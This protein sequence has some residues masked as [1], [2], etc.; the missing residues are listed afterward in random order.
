MSDAPYGVR[1]WRSSR[2]DDELYADGLTV[3]EDLLEHVA[4][5]LAVNADRRRAAA[6]AHSLWEHMRLCGEQDA[7]EKLLAWLKGSR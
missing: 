6:A 1:G 3:R 5:Q 2:S 7:Y 4:G